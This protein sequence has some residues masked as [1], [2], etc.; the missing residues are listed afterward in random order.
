MKGRLIVLIGLLMFLGGGIVS[1]MQQDWALI[2]LFLGGLIGGLV[3][4]RRIRSARQAS[5]ALQ[6][7]TGS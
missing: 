4:L 7:D 2:V 6:S 3:L 5:A 1:A